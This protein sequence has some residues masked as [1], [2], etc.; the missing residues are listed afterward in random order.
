[1]SKIKIETL[2]PIHIGSGNKISRME[3]TTFKDGGDRFIGIV[4]PEKVIALIGEENISNWVSFISQGKPLGDFVKKYAPQARPQDYISRSILLFPDDG[5][6]LKECLHNGLGQPYIPGSSI[7]GA[8]RTA[9]IAHAAQGRNLASQID[10]NGRP[11]AKNVEFAL[12]ANC[13][14]RGDGPNSEFF[15]FLKVGD[16]YFKKDCEIALMAVNLNIRSSHDDL[17]DESKKMLTEAIAADSNA[18]FSLKIEKELSDWCAAQKARVSVKAIPDFMKDVE[19]LFRVVNNH[20]ISLLKSEIEYWNR[21]DKSGADD[22]IENMEAMLSEAKSCD[23][24]SCVLRI[25]AGSGWRF[26]TGAWTEQYDNFESFIVP[27]ARPRNNVYREY[28]FPKSRRIDRD[29]DVF[30]FVKLTEK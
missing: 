29:G 11:S 6:E 2:S 15:R 10:V 13:F 20:T 25:G 21:I 9:I 24:K 28:D 23:S 30:G 7:K 8:L 16:A 4:S 3:M 19:S 14:S 27:A 12:T 26:M 18:E 17:V 5:G 22:Y 1:M